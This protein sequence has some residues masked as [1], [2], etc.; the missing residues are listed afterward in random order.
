MFCFYVQSS[1]WSDVPSSRQGAHRTVHNILHLK[2]N[3][4]LETMQRMQAKFKNSEPKREYVSEIQFS[5]PGHYPVFI[6]FSTIKKNGFDTSLCMPKSC[7]LY[8]NMKFLIKVA[9]N[10]RRKKAD[11]PIHWRKFLPLFIFSP[12]LSFSVP[13]YSD[14]SYFV[15]EDKIFGSS[16]FRRSFSTDRLE[17]KISP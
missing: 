8:R 2:L 17:E 5:I 10:C 14:F 7:Y 9:F 6:P 16:G 1:S 11:N 15:Y 4:N 12:F 13:Y 3:A